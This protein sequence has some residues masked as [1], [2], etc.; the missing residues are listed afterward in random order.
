MKTKIFFLFLLA[1][2][3]SVFYIPKSVYAQDD[4]DF[5]EFMGMM[6]VNFTNG[7]LDELSFQLPWDIRVTGYSYGD[8]S[9]DG[10]NDFVIAV[11][12]K[13]VTPDGTVDVYFI[14]NIGD[15]T[16]TVVKKK[17]YKFYD[18]TLEVAFI[19]QYGECFVTNRDKNNWYF[20]GYKI[21]DDDSLVQV[22]KETYPM[23][24]IEN[25]GR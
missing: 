4:M 22:E 1:I 19:V 20:T 5:E 10:L 11:K 23:E 13:D 8:F 2:S 7:Q 15:T 24:T 9:G 3:L 6:S 17:N 18:L 21:N 25:A 16:F 14:K 12:Q